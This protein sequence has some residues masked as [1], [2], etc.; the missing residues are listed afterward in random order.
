[1]RQW[2]SGNNGPEP[3]YGIYFSNTNEGWALTLKGILHTNNKGFSWEK[4]FECNN[5]DGWR[6]YPGNLFILEKNVLIIRGPA[7][8]LRYFYSSG[9]RGITWNKVNV[10]SIEEYHQN[11]D[12]LIESFGGKLVHYGGIYSKEGPDKE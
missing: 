9:D 6:F 1:M 7:T 11:F 8:F 5:T 12:N 4:I 2:F 3:V 10:R